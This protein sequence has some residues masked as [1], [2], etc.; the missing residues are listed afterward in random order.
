[1]RQWLRHLWNLLRGRVV[2][3]LLLVAVPVHAGTWSW[4][5]SAWKT[6]QARQATPTATRTVAQPTA[7]PTVSVTVAETPVP[8]V[9]NRLEVT[10]GEYATSARATATPVPDMSGTWVHPLI[11]PLVG[12]TQLATYPAPARVYLTRIYATPR[13]RAVLWIVQPGDLQDPTS[14]SELWY[15]HV[16]VPDVPARKL[17]DIHRI[18]RE[19]VYLSAVSPDGTQIAV[20]INELTNWK[21]LKAGGRPRITHQYF[22]RLNID[23]TWALPLQV[24]RPITTNL[25]THGGVGDMV[26]TEGR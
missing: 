10:T 8:W 9:G 15:A 19:P 5:S 17:V 11:A 12:T 26:W 13:G 22:G 1:M 3:C 7:S 4:A 25:G 16:G 24:K 23:G 6:E 14:P 18:D 21:S 20:V 2:W